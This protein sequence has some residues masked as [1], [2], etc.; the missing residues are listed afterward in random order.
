MTVTFTPAT[1]RYAAI[2]AHVE[3]ATKA[4]ESA[5][6]RNLFALTLVERAALDAGDPPPPRPGIGRPQTG[7]TE[8]AA[9]KAAVL[10]DYAAA[11]PATTTKAEH[12]MLCQRL[13]AHHGVSPV[14]V[15][16]VTADWREKHNVHVP[17]Y[18]ADGDALRPGEV[19]LLQS[20]AA[21]PGVV[22]AERLATILGRTNAKAV[23]AIVAATRGRLVSL[24]G[25]PDAAHVIVSTHGCGY[26]LDRDAAGR[27]PVVVAA[28]EGCVP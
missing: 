17:T 23:A 18:V 4:T 20:L 8:R 2:V 16:T 14:F 21:E 24:T 12:A 6:P 9:R 15:K 27:Y 10:A 13:A 26:D 3:R 22:R 28:L 1:N 25:D 5:P 19:D 11:F 7:D